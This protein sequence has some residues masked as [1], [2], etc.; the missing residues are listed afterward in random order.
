MHFLFLFMHTVLHYAEELLPLS[1]KAATFQRA[2]IFRMEEF[3]R[4]GDQFEAGS[5]LTYLR[6]MLID[7]LQTTDR[8]IPEY[9]TV[10]DHGCGTVS[11]LMLCLYTVLY[12]R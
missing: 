11:S 5:R 9:R 6:E 4:A 12:D 2:S 1:H 10:H 3:C 7:L 8:Y